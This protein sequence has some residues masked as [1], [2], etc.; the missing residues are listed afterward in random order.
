MFNHADIDECA[1]DD[2]NLCDNV[3]RAICTNTIGSYNCS[4]K[5]GFSG[6]GTTCTGWL[7]KYSEHNKRN[8]PLCECLFYDVF[9]MHRYK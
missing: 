1:S 2:L 6:D 7:Q 4:C 3:T 5:S 9:C 8:P